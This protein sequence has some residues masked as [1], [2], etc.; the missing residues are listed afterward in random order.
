MFARDFGKDIAKVGRNGEVAAFVQLVRSQSLPI[1]VN[2]SALDRVSKNEHRVAVTV[3][4]AAAAV[5]ACRASEF[6]HRKHDNVVHSRPEIYSER[7]DRRREI[8]KKIRKLPARSALID[9][10]VPSTGVRERDLQSDARLYHL[11]DLHQ[12]TT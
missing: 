2:L 12:R 6:G 1:A 3:I 11:R 5:L 4:G 9:M 8:A 7:G 10:R